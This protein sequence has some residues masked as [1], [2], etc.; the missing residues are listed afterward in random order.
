MVQDLPILGFSLKRMTEQQEPYEPRGSRTDLWGPR[1]E[2]PLGYPADSCDSR[3]SIMR[4]TLILFG[5]QEVEDAQKET[6]MAAE[7]KQSFE[8]VLQTVCEYFDISSEELRGKGRTPTLVDGRSVLA[9]A[10]RYIPGSSFGDVC[11]IL[12]KHHGTVSRLAKRAEE[13]AVL[14]DITRRL[15]CMNK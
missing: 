10:T 5:S 1:G 4:I 12:G 6:N 13:S 8:E 2:I 3:L 15:L 9:Y 7:V 14:K 11:R